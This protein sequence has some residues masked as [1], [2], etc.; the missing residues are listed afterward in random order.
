[1]SLEV[2]P[3]DTMNIH[4]SLRQP[5]WMFHEVISFG[6]LVHREIVDNDGNAWRQPSE[7]R[8]GERI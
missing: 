1:M 2:W 6:V 7:F 8:L 5:E 4:R 3:N